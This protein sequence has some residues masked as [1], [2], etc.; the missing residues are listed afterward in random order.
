MPKTEYHIVSEQGC[1]AESVFASFAECLDDELKKG[2]HVSPD[3]YH[4]DTSQLVP[5]QVGMLGNAARVGYIPVFMV[6]VQVEREAKED[7]QLDDA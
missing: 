1:D 6:C 7:A 3:T 4:S 5:S 2:W